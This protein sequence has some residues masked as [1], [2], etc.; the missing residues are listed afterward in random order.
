M[1]VKS[2]WR[3]GQA[4]HKEGEEQS[5]R[6]APHVK[7]SILRS[8]RRG[9][10]RREFLME[11]NVKDVTDDDDAMKLLKLWLIYIQDFHQNKSLIIL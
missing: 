3:V 9:V 6:A 7:F 4:E 11:F 5:S 8:E 2:V 1:A 10:E